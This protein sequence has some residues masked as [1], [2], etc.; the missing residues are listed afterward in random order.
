[1]IKL[2]LALTLFTLGCGF[3]GIGI[4]TVTWNYIGGGCMLALAATIYAYQLEKNN[5]DL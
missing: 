5:D 4:V 2:L 1:M 3:A